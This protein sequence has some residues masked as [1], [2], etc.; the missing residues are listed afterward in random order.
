MIIHI[1]TY[2]PEK[3]GLALY[4]HDLVRYLRMVDPT[5]THKVL[6][7]R[8]Y[9]REPYGEDVIFQ[10]EKDNRESYRAV[11]NFLNGNEGVE[12]T[13]LLCVEQGR[14]IFQVGDELRQNNGSVKTC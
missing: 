2:P 7:V 14:S 4:T 13:I 8:A 6:A 11:A 1:S 9:C 3:C 5:E 10:I 12:A